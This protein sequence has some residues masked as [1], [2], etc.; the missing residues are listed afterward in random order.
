GRLAARPALAETIVPAMNPANRID[1]VFVGDGYTADEMDVYAEHVDLQA[2]GFFSREP[3]IT[4]APYF[5]LHRVD[6]ISSESGVD[7]DP[8]LGVQRGTALDMGFWCHGLERLLCI[9]G[10]AA[11]SCANNAPAVDLVVAVANSTKYGGSGYIASALATVSGGNGQATQILL[12]EFGHALGNLAD[13]YF[14]ADGSHWA[15]GEV[16]EPNAS[17]FEADEMLS[18]QTKWFRWIGVS[19]R[20]FDG[21]VGAFEGARYFQFGLYRPTANSL[22]RNLNRPYNLPSVE[23]LV[24]EM[25]KMVDP[26]DDAS[27]V[28]EIYGPGDVLIV[29]PIDP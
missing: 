7:N 21:L 1:L 26:I 11:D 28:D 17:V 22:M 19:D 23:S 20:E 6:V 27:P 18:R 15:G 29:D 2:A 16:P 4:Y 10:A 9:D 13:E 3:F 14:D 24:I 8:V 12:H 25:Y 5:A